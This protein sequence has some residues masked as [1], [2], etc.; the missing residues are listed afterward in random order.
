MRTVP[1]RYLTRINT[2]VLPE[3]TSP[4]LTFKY[5]D[6]SQVDSN[7]TLSLPEEELCFGEAPSR[8]RRLAS[9][10]DTVVSTVRTY[11]R[12]IAWVPATAEPLVFS[13]GFAVLEPVEVESR[14]LAYACRS[15]PFVAEVVARSTGVSYPAINPSDLASIA[16]PMPEAQEQRRIADFLDD[17][18]DRIDRIIAGR[19]RQADLAVFARLA[20]MSERMDEL[21]ADFGVAPLRRFTSGIEQGASPVGED[22][23]AEPGEAGVLKT[24][25]ILAGSFRPDQNKVV[26]I[27]VVD[28]R[29]LV[30]NG[31]VLVT[32]GS[33]S[34]HLVGD[35]A[36][37][38]PHNGQ[39]LYLSDLTYRLKALR[40]LPDFAC[41]SII[42]ARGRADLGSL[43]RQG[44]GP[45]KAR[46]EDVLAVGVPRAPIAVQK[47]VVAD[48]LDL[49]LHGTRGS[50]TLD[51]S[52]RI[53]GELKQ[54][55]ITAAVT[56]E[57]DVTTAGS[58]VPG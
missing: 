10:G 40:L 39:P 48:W 55:L 28:A 49:E 24:S 33:G 11:L 41:L 54:S 57:L 2:R 47:S 30:H 12:A 17:R 56:G 26:P 13:T 1:L 7:G 15:E 8:A 3:L 19:R 52:I 38:R 44:S 21:A 43:V 37:A 6:I 9:V 58:S 23:P 18:V 22:R 27:D 46:G 42:S 20:S 50:S 5:I 32:R 31:D 51:T 4:E 35:A 29:F 45:A 25:A 16:L 53:L 14:F 36:V 34:A